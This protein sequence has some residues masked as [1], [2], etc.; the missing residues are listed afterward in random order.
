[1]SCP[2]HVGNRKAGCIVLYEYFDFGMKL[3]VIVNKSQAGTGSDR[4]RSVHRRT[5]SCACARVQDRRNSDLE[6]IRR[7]VQITP[8]L[9]EVIR[10]AYEFE[11]ARTYRRQGDQGGEK[12]RLWHWCSPSSRNSVPTDEK[13]HLLERRPD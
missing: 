8:R 9:L 5:E 3:L 10:N 6:T 1:M 11:R 13:I 7:H 12:E 2:K 4:Q